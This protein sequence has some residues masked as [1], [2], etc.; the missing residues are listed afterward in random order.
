MIYAPL[1]YGMLAT[2]YT[3]QTT[4][5]IGMPHDCVADYYLTGGE[6]IVYGV[7]RYL[8]CPSDQAYVYVANSISVQLTN[9][10][11]QRFG[12]L[13]DKLVCGRVVYVGEGVSQA[14]ERQDTYISICNSSLIDMFNYSRDSYSIS[15][16]HLDDRREYECVSIAHNRGSSTTV[17]Y[18][19]NRSRKMILMTLYANNL[20]FLNSKEISVHSLDHPSEV[21]IGV[22]KGNDPLVLEYKKFG[23]G[24]PEQGDDPLTVTIYQVVG[25]ASIEVS[26]YCEL[27][28]SKYACIHSILI[29]EDQDPDKNLVLSLMY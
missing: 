23:W 19:Y 18:C 14:G 5:A 6:V 11:K 3:A 7:D 24:I 10:T 12:V 9:M 15:G 25:H 26:Y 28:R 27:D 2:L 20:A 17:T 22:R 4:T 1:F 16:S 29:P 13:T 21:T 8:R